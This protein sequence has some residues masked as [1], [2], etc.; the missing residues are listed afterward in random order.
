MVK[1]V[2]TKKGSGFTL[3]PI[4]SLVRIGW[5]HPLP[6]CQ[7]VGPNPG[8]LGVSFLCSH[9]HCYHRADCIVFTLVF[10]FY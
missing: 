7:H 5:A 10:G 2:A 4:K 3:R 6:P 1:I 8:R 9:C